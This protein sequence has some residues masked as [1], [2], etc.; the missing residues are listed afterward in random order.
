MGYSGLVLIH[1]LLVG[2]I[3]RSGVGSYDGSSGGR[4]IRGGRNGGGSSTLL[5]EPVLVSADG[6]ELVWELFLVVVLDSSS[7]YSVV[8]DTPSELVMK[9]ATVKLGLIVLY[10]T[11]LRICHFTGV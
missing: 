2:G 4:Y 1:P 8:F 5:I 3:L 11:P 6:E 7:E 9:G 10:V